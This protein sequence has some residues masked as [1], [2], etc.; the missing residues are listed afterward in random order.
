MRVLVT[1]SPGTTPPVIST[2]AWVCLPDFSYQQLR[3][4]GW[5]PVVGDWLH[6]TSASSAATRAATS[7]AQP[8]EEN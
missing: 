3:A 4:A 8:R 7:K 2:V 5:R 6:S 1:A